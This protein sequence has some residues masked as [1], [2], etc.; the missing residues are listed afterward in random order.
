M[1]RQSRLSHPTFLDYVPIFPRDAYLT[2]N[3]H[4]TDLALNFSFFIGKSVEIFLQPEVLNVFN[5]SAVIDRN[6]VINTRRYGCSSSVCQ[7][8]DPFDASYT[9]VEGLDYEFGDNFGEPD[10]DGDYQLPRTYR[11]SVGIRF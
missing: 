5:E 10:N 11:V 1:D 2:D 7:Y 9:P 6:E 4:R 8:F 3:V